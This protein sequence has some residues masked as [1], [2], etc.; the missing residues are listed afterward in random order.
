MRRS[1]LGLVLF[2]PACLPPL[3]SNSASSNSASTDA[4]AACTGDN[5]VKCC[6]SS[7]CYCQ[8]SCPTCDPNNYRVC[9]DFGGRFQCICVQ[10]GDLTSGTTGTTGTTGA[11]T[12]GT[13]GSSGFGSSSSTF[14]SSSGGNVGTTT[15]QSSSSSS[16][17]SGS[18]ST[19]NS[20]TT[21]GLC[22]Y[23]DTTCST[24]EECCSGFCSGVCVAC[25][26]GNAPNCGTLG[27]TGCSDV[28]S[29]H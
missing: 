18:N 21:G 8:Y 17:A 16:S 9:G 7:D 5:V 15:T 10:S 23:L 24:D 22:Q 11:D 19:G 4:G 14:G 2:C 12:T 13:L 27:T 29:C 25:P 3:D 6:D 26:G 1:L 20:G 28:S